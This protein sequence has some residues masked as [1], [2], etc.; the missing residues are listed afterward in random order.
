MN[1]E[2]DFNRALQA[3][4]EDDA[5]RLVYADWLEERGDQR[6]ELIRLLHTL[7]QSIEVPKRGKLEDRLRRLVSAG[8][9]PVGP[10][11]TNSIGMS[12]AWIPA[13]TLLMGS[14]VTEKGRTDDEIQHKVTLTRGFYLGCYPVTQA[15]WRAVMGR[16]PSL[17]KGQPKEWPVELVTWEDC[18]EF[19]Q[20]L[21]EREGL[22]YRFPS[23]SEWEYACRAGTTTPYFFGRHI[24]GKQARFGYKRPRNVGRF[25]PN[26]FGLCGMHGEV[27]EWCGDWY[28]V[29]PTEEAV[30]PQGPPTGTCRVFRGGGPPDVARCVRSAFRRSNAPSKRGAEI[31]VRLAR[32]FP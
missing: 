20:K 12:F 6:S 29:Y 25:P 10:F 11:W 26:A 3:N 7:T 30:D 5:T 2:A 1:D 21:S 27:W 18:R 24:T 16:N 4:P 13:G 22:T 31:G 15:Q 8:V 23:E 14:P 9:Q 19:I 17:F 32:T 28:G